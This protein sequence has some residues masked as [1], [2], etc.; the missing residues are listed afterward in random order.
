MTTRKT[1]TIDRYIDNVIIA[2]CEIPEQSTI[3]KSIINRVAK[4]ITDI[5]NVL[6]SEHNIQIKPDFNLIKNQLD[7]NTLNRIKI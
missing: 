5:A 6:N 4:K 3:K 7:E 2:L 1:M